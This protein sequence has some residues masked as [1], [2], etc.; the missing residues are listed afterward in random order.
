[1]SQHTKIINICLDGEWHCQ[2][3]FRANYIFSPHKRRIEIEGRKNK[4]EK[5]T[6]K[7]IFE[8]RACEHDVSGQRDYRMSKNLDYIPYKT[9]SPEDQEKESDILLQRALM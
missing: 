7:Y 8:D 5:A 2:N 9:P 3:E 4:R 6:G 1:M